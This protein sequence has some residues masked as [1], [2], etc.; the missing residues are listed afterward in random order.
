MQ[1][2]KRNISVF[3]YTSK[4]NVFNFTI[5]DLKGNECECFVWDESN[6]HWGIN[7]LGSCILFFNKRVA[8]GDND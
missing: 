1:F 3:Y 4:L 8:S 6:G 2:P 7:E 5:Y